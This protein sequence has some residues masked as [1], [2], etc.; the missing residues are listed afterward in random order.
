MLEKS[1]ARVFRDFA[2]KTGFA[3]ANSRG[4]NSFSIKTN[5]LVLV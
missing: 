4:G 2:R 1:N 5:M 3:K